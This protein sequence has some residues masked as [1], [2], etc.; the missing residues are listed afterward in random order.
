MRRIEY[1]ES[2]VA[3]AIEELNRLNAL[4]SADAIADELRA[5]GIRGNHSCS[6]CP[7]AESMWRACDAALKGI[8]VDEIPACGS[9]PSIE[10]TWSRSVLAGERVCTVRTP[11]LEDSRVGSGPQET[12]FETPENVARFIILFDNT[13][14]P[15]RDLISLA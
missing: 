9:V 15:Y 8:L 6:A 5:R 13:D 11:R 10:G 2:V 1:H 14:G 3:A 12:I 7:I 4:G